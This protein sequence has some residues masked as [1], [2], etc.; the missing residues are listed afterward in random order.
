MEIF[1]PFR[2]TSQRNIEFSMLLFLLPFKGSWNFPCSLFF[3]PSKDHGI[4]HAP[5]SFRG[6]WNFLCS[7]SLYYSNEYGNFYA[8]YRCTTQRNVKNFYVPYRCISLKGTCKFPR[9]F[10]LCLCSGTLCYICL[11]YTSPSP[12]DL[13]T[14][15]MP[16]SA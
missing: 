5:Y 13:S 14:S 11:L 16:S 1:V 6:T 7:L 10:K 4:F 12:R 9:L 8:P 15:R 2:C 3:Y